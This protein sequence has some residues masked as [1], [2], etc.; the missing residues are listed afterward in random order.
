M[1]TTTDF[2]MRPFD[3]HIPNLE[4]D[5]TA[6]TIRIEV[7]VRV[8]AATG[9]EILLPEAHDLIEKTKARRMG[10]MLPEDIREL[11]ERISL[12]QEDM[13]HLLQ[14]GAKSYTRWESGHARVSRSMNV[15][16]CALRDGVISVEY[17][18]CLR[19][20][21]DWTELLKRRVKNSIVFLS[22]SSETP[23]ALSC[24]RINMESGAA[25]RDAQQELGLPL[26]A[27]SGARPVSKLQTCDST[28]AWTETDQAA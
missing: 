20:G 7:P 5:G 10:L 4:G 9:Q 27:P 8:D 21:R 22:H 16:L 28:V 17:L 2:Q 14:I 15:L 24:M 3:V 11:R 12:N 26:P 18:R 1:K 13:S 19:D 23:R 25:F 6:E